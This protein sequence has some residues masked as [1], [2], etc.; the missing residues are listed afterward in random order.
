MVS[1]ANLLSVFLTYIHTFKNKN[2][3]KSL[4]YIFVYHILV[5][6]KDAITTKHM[7]RSKI[8]FRVRSKAAT[9]RVL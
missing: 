7:M 5:Y 4:R 9:T 2:R 6:N 8:H 3:R 1:F